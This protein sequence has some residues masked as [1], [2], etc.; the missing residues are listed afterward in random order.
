V[1]TAT[2]GNLGTQ[3]PT[4]W[5]E[6]AGTPQGVDLTLTGTTITSVS[7]SPTD[8]NALV[9]GAIFRARSFL[10][11]VTYR[12]ALKS[13]YV[14]DENQKAVDGDHLPPWV[15]Q[16]HSGDQIEGGTFESWFTMEGSA[17][18]KSTPVVTT[19]APATGKK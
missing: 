2:S 12:V 16:R 5:C 6:I 10:P 8:P 13:D 4:C 18:G 1:S 9:L 11:G 7:G 15:P 14:R 3:S 17:A 19:K